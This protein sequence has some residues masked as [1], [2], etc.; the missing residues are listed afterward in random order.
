MRTHPHYKII[1]DLGGPA[2]VARQISKRMK[3]A[4]PLRDNAVTNWRR[5]GIP[6]NRV[7]HT[8]ADMAIEAGV[9]IPKNFL[10]GC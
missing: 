3:R 10:V 7:R 1:L 9:K 5:R 4:T 8:I 2:E 6:K